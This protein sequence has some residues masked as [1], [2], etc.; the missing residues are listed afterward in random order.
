MIS[1]EEGYEELLIG[2]NFDM[3][4]EIHK[5]LMKVKSIRS[6]FTFRFEGAELSQVYISSQ[7]HDRI[8]QLFAFVCYEE[9]QV[10]KSPI[11]SRYENSSAM[12]H[13]THA[14]GR[15]QKT[16]APYATTKPRKNPPFT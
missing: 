15:M 14:Y 10:M 11:L 6:G 9:S 16:L 5:M 8:R 13:K 2:F 1:G 4:R 12:L 3:S 7:F